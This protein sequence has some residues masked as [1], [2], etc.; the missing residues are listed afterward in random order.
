M[1]DPVPNPYV[2]A[3]AFGAKT[4]RESSTREAPQ[5]DTRPVVL[6]FAKAYAA[7][8][9]QRD[10]S[11]DFDRLLDEAVDLA[12]RVGCRVASRW[13]GGDGGGARW[14]RGQLRIVLDG[15]ASARL[16][17]LTIANAL[18]GNPSLAEAAMSR[19]L[20]AYLRPRRAA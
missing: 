13:L 4:D 7:R 8:E 16:R 17:L 10:A 6:S 2:L 5:R 12:R 14:D 3:G 11:D 20:A 1:P 9:A 19:E 18:R 15:E